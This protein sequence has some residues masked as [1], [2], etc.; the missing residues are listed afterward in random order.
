MLRY[1]SYELE[2]ENSI[3]IT[4][5]FSFADEH[6]RHLVQ[7]SLSNPKLQVYV[8]CFDEVELNSMKAMFEEYSNV[9]YVCLD[10]VLN[11]DAFN[12][13]VFHLPAEANEDVSDGSD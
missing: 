4:F 13:K 5:G 10:S 12:S 1:M 6:I 3:L 8:C 11:F 9:S 2:A 7:R